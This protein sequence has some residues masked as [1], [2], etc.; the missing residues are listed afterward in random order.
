[1]GFF[2]CKQ[3]SQNRKSMASLEFRKNV[4]EN[5]S[6]YFRHSKLL[7]L[8][9]EQEEKCARSDSGQLTLQRLRTKVDKGRKVERKLR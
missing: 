4:E 1:M 9:L 8:M 2:I 6:K 7:S 5:G 3:K